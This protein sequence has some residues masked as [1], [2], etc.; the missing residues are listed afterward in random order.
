MTILPGP[1][2]CVGGPLDGQMHCARSGNVLV[3]PPPR[4]T[5]WDPTK[6]LSS[7]AP[8]I[9]VRIYS[10]LTF[11]GRRKI[12]APRGQSI[13]ETEALLLA[14]DYPEARLFQEARAAI[15]KES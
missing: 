6:P 10:M 2:R 8:G 13:E 7:I 12:W 15:V 1:Y 3:A 5:R 11:G 4:E 9:E 14:G